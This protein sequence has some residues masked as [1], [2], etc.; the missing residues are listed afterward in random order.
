MEKLIVLKIII[1]LEFLSPEYLNICIWL[2]F[3]KFTKKTWVDN[4]KTNGNISNS[5][6]G[7]FNKA[8]YMG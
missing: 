8:I 3:N 6:E 2:L 1:I 7:V 4:K 5:N